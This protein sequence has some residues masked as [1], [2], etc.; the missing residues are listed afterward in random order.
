MK[1]YHF[2]FQRYRLE[3]YT[4]T[5]NWL[6]SGM[7][8]LFGLLS[9]SRSVALF[10]GYHGPLDL[11]PEFYR[12]ATDPT[13]HTVPEGRPV[14]VCV[15]KEWYRFPSSF[16]LPDNWQL[17]FIPSEFRGQLPKPFAEGPLATRI[18]PTDVN[19]QNLEEPS[20]Y[21]MDVTADTLLTAGLDGDHHEDMESQKVGHVHYNGSG[22]GT[23]SE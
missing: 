12:I 2:V 17:Q 11:Y 4:V 19:D 18:V 14:N 3:H 8:V 22:G 23:G 15:G 13:I 21:Q 5:S 6:A 9:F 7:L 1:C 16:L 20:R 10:K